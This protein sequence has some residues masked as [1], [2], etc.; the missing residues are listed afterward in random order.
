M[1]LVLACFALVF[2]APALAQPSAREAYEAGDWAYTQTL[3]ADASDA[4]SKTY[5]AEAAIAPLILGEMTGADRY[6]K[7][8]RAR[9]AA[10]L[11]REALEID[12]EH[13]RAHLALATALGYEAR[14]TNPIRA[15]LARLPQR[16]RAHIQRAL[17]LD[18]ADPRANALLGAWHL[19]IVRRAGEPTFGAD[20]ETGLGRYRA[21]ATVAESPAIPYHFAL[22]LLA[23]DADAHGDEAIAQ[24]RAAAAMEAD[25]AFETAMKARAEELLEIAETLRAAAAEQAVIRLQQ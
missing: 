3:A 9:T 19:E 21:A 8:T 17:E 22:A 10:G 1:R 6:D 25:T 16:G 23:L 4:V 15:A 18:P 2:A 14:Y 11:A 12:P 20:A 7:R 13:V 5:A 24:L